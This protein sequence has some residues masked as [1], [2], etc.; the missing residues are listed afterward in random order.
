MSIPLEVKSS[1]RSHMILL[2]GKNG[3]TMVSSNGYGGIFNLEEGIPY[4]LI[5]GNR[6]D[7]GL[8]K[9]LVDAGSDDNILR[10]LLIDGVSDF[11]QKDHVVSVCEIMHVPEK[12][13]QELLS[14]VHLNN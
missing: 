2:S 9:I 3:E 14:F 1:T 13:T 12:V 11:T 5:F 6:D 10:I 8:E 4:W 7:A